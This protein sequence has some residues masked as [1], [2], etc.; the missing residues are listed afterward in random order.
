LG[1]LVIG[2]VYAKTFDD[3]YFKGVL[4]Y[5][6]SFLIGFVMLMI[7]IF[8]GAI[9]AVLLSKTM[10]LDWFESLKPQ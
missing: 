6:G 10:G 7:F 9:I 4:R 5:I 8:V 3:S 1:F 2:R